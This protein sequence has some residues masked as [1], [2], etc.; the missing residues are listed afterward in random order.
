[1]PYRM[2]LTKWSL[3]QAGVVLR[4]QKAKVM[5]GEVKLFTVSLVLPFRLTAW[6]PDRLSSIWL[7]A[8]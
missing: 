5:F 2:A 3:A 6:S 8:L 1:M 4:L 7:D